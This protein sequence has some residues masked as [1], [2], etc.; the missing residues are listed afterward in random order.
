MKNLIMLFGALVLLIPACYSSDP[1]VDEPMCLVDE[2]CDDGN[3]MSV[4][5]CREGECRHAT[6]FPP[7]TTDTL[8][9]RNCTNGEDD[10]MDGLIDCDDTSCF[11]HEACLQFLPGYELPI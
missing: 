10:D 7:D 1:V 4:D 6:P 5:V 11:E 8:P 9:E 2:D 3:P